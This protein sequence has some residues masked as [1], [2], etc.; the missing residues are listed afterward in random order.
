[1]TEG[2]GNAVGPCKNLPLFHLLDSRLWD[3][4]VISVDSVTHN[5]KL[6]CCEFPNGVIMRIP[7][8]RHIH[9]TRDVEGSFWNCKGLL[10]LILIVCSSY[11]QSN[12]YIMEKIFITLVS[13]L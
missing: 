5:C 1:M 10:C 4:R 2:L 8:G 12:E 6:F 9:L 13:L 7:V 11:E 3:C